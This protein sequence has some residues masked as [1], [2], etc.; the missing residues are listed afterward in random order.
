MEPIKDIVNIIFPSP[1]LILCIW[2]LIVVTCICGDYLLLLVSDTDWLG[3]GHIV[4]SVIDSSIHAIVSVL[5]W[6]VVENFEHLND[7]RK[8]Q[9]CACCA[10]LA[11]AVDTDHFLAA[12]SLDFRKA[13]NLTKR[14]CFHN[15]SL[16][17]AVVALCLI[18]RQY[19][20]A[21]KMFSV[22]FLSS[23]LSHHLR[24]AGHRGLWVFPFGH[25]PVFPSYLYIALTLLLTVLVRIIYCVAF[26][27]GFHL[28]THL[29]EILNV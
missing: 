19:I 10:V 16:I 14:P 8:W 15:T 13:L 12:G 29:F 28:N 9:N 24:D 4:R 6:A 27:T 25:T 7:F 23:W 5:V 11:V 26:N 22:M 3:N 2:S 18:M 21:L 20:P 17:L 1:T